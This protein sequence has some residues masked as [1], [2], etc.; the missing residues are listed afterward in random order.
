M[1]MVRNPN[2]IAEI[3]KKHCGILVP[4]C[5]RK[6]TLTLDFEQMHTEI[7]TAYPL[8]L[9]QQTEIPKNEHTT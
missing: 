9:N 4:K 7:E 2:D 8:L 6:L 1:N 5:A 3:L